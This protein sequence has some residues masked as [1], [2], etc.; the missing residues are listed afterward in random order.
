MHDNK[1]DSECQT[2]VLF[3]VYVIWCRKNN[4]YYIGVTGQEDVYTRIYQHKY[5][6]LFIDREIK[7]VGWENFD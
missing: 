1:K 2:N 3:A 5:G 7:N 6:K 4:M